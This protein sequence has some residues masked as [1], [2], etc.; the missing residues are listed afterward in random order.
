L[1]A[2]STRGRLGYPRRE[3]L[4]LFPSRRCF[5][6][7]T[8]PRFLR[9]GFIL[10]CRIPS[11]EL[12]R[13]ISLPPPFRAARPAGGFVPLRDINRR[14]LRIARDPA[15]AM[16]R[17]QVF[18]TSRRL[19]PCV[20]LRAYFIPLARP[21]FPLQGLPFPGSRAASRRPVPS[22]RCRRPSFATRTTKKRPLDFRALLPLG[23]RCAFGVPLGLPTARCPH[24]VHPRQG[25]PFLGRSP[26]FRRPPLSS[27]S[28]ERQDVRAPAPQGLPEPRTRLVSRET[29]DPL[30]VPDLVELLIRSG[31]HRTGLIVSPRA[32]RRVATP[33]LRPSL[34]RAASLP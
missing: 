30:E 5:L 28:R 19:A 3:R 16:S 11:S 15:P 25:L 1:C 2:G 23:V 24:G 4:R 13:R 6:D 21:G 31:R 20:T 8:V 12:L 33:P 18:A 17:P 34:A 22:C 14:C 27:F 7:P 26:R 10:S 29:A 9:I 32:R